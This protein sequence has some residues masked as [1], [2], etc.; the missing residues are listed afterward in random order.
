MTP[1]HHIHKWFRPKLLLQ[2]WKCTIVQNVCVCCRTG[3][4]MVVLEEIWKNKDLI[5]VLTLTLLNTFGMT[6]YT[7]CIPGLLTQ[8]QYIASLML[9]CLKGNK[10]LK[11]QSSIQCKSF[12]EKWRMNK[13]QR[14]D[15]LWKIYP[16]S[17]LRSGL[18][19]GAV[20]EQHY[21]AGKYYIDN[22]IRWSGSYNTVKPIKLND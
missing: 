20:R 9:L 16:Y 11:P 7:D 17:N 12:P 8:H 15:K 5:R 21:H 19:S 2:S 6:W 13:H 4:A 22:Y 1:D 3:F 10:F 14:E 18:N